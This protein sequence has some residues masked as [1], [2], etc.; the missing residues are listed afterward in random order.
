MIIGI[1]SDTHGTLN[2]EVL[3]IFK[4][5][6][7][8]IHAGDIGSAEIISILAQV[9]PVTAVRG[10]TDNSDWSQSIPYREMISLAGLGIY[11]LHDLQQLD[12]EPPAAGISAVISGHTHQP[13]ICQRDGVL[14][15]NP[16]SASQ[17]RHGGPLSVGRIRIAGQRLHSE[18]I[19]LR[20]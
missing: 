5:A 17:R 8:I 13:E 3:K 9:A 6:T 14:Y 16:G 4:G 20:L 19:H 1:I 18:I 15:M 11:I 7:H 2:A 10:N 12:V